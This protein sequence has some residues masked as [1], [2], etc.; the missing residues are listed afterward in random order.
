MAS[1]RDSVASIPYFAVWVEGDAPQV[2]RSSDFVRASKMPALQ[3]PPMSDDLEDVIN[4]SMG[5]KITDFASG[6]MGQMVGRGE[7]FDL[8]DEALKS[9]GAKTATDYDPKLKDP[10]YKWGDETS[11]Q[12]AKKG[13]IIQF[14]KVTLEYDDGSSME[15]SHHTAIVSSVGGKG[16][17]WIYEQNGAGGKKVCHVK[18]DLSKLTSGS[19]KIY[20]PV[21][22]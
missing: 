18:I 16:V 4:P 20:H 17:L 6:K 10:D 13:D 22:K 21:A 11:L 14:K 9:V 19:Y 2:E 7:C 8:A 5:T 12:G 3:E 1:R 15:Y